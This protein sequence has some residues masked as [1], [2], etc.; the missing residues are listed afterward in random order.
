MYR[1]KALVEL[2]AAAR[3]CQ[4]ERLERMMPEERQALEALRE[5]RNKDQECEWEDAGNIV[6]EDVLD[7]TEQLEELLGELFK[8]YSR[9]G[10]RR[11]DY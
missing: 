2:A 3:K 6:F 1:H 8:D 9:K 7:G 5:E 11:K 10:P 4:Q